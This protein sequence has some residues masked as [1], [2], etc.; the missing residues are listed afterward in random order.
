[1]IICNDSNDKCYIVCYF[2][3]SLFPVEEIKATSQ[4]ANRRAK[5]KFSEGLEANGRLLY[6]IKMGFSIVGYIYTECCQNIFK[7]E[8]IIKANVQNQN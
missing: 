7:I 3:T 2:G 6:G 8:T 1:M 4:R 5:T